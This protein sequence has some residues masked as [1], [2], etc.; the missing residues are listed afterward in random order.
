M[1]MLAVNNEALCSLVNRRA[2]FGWDDMS[3]V[4]RQIQ[5]AKD[6]EDYVDRRDDGNTNNSGWYRIA[7]DSGQARSL[8]SQGKLAV[9]LGTEVPSLFGCRKN[10]TA[11][12][13]HYVHRGFDDRVR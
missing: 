6:P 7:Y 11:C 4:D 2:G 12:T 3:A 9:V 1:V 5:A 10:N 8:I 13:E